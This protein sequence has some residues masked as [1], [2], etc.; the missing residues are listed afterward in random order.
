MAWFLGTCS[1]KVLDIFKIQEK[2][3]SEKQKIKT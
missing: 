1:F 2:I 3:L